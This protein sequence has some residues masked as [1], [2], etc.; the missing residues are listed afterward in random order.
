MEVDE[1]REAKTRKRHTRMNAEKAIEIQRLYESGTSTKDIADKIDMSIRS[2]QTYINDHMSDQLGKPWAP[3][4]PPKSIGKRPSLERRKAILEI[5]EG[6]N[7]LTQI[8]MIDKLP[9]TLRCGRRTL[10]RDLR[11]LN[12]TRK[13]LRHMPIE[14]NDVVTLASRHDYAL[15]VADIA[16]EKLFFIDETGTNLHTNTNYGYSFRGITPTLEEPGNRGQN[17]SILA[18]VGL[19]GIIHFERK[20]GA[21]NA[22][23]FK[24]F[25]EDLIGMLPADV[26]IVLDNAAIHKGREVRELVDSSGRHLKFLPRYSPQLNPIEQF[27]AQYKAHQKAI[28]PRPRNLNQL[29]ESIDS[30]MN[31]VR[32][33]R[34]RPYYREMRRYVSMALANKKFL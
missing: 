3:F 25:V 11:S 33:Q 9:A 30:A 23:A 12:I 7:S 24:Q 29:I 16:D 26:I 4:V 31:S 20:P 18:C 34:M 5:V 6:D 22:E 10:Q 14:R 32:Y 15:E 19:N 17:Q 2:V 28:R 13:R 27:F 8:Q 21:Y 1:E